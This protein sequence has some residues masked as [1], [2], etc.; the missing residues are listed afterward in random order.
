MTVG[1]TIDYMR[2]NARPAARFG[3]Y[4][5]DHDRALSALA[6]DC[7]CG[8]RAVPISS[9]SRRAWSVRATDD[10][11]VARLF[12]RYDL[13]AAPVVDDDGRWLA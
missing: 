11:R 13:V 3:V 8:P 7:C 10:Q 5:A 2:E 1:Q 12:E 6:L 4:V 9:R